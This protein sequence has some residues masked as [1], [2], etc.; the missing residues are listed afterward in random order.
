M[1]NR[2][3]PLSAA[4]LDS[5]AW[6]KVNGLLPAVVQDDVSGLV[7]MLGYVSR[8][9]LAATIDSGF[10][11]FY[12][13]S[14]ERLWMKGETSGNRLRLVELRADCDDDAVL[15]LADPEGPTCHTGAASCFAHQPA[16]AAW[17][18]VLSRIIADRADASEAESY[19][20]RLLAKGVEKIAQK[21]GEE[22]VEV[23]L[24]AVTRDNAG[25]AEEAADLLYHLS[26]LLQAK[27]MRWD[28]VTQ[29][30]RERHKI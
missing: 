6:D 25:I 26:V 28:D 10:V 15:I 16:G 12:S 20:A 19:T 8:E 17:L 21:I 22:G 18:G 1:R 11:T 7:L 29:I 24:A 14:K 3:A 23:S 2:N 9:S 27:G 4:D 30:L 13:R 5:L